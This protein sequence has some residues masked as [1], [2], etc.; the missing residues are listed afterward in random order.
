MHG[1]GR[2]GAPENT[3]AL[4]K[5]I[6]DFF[7]GKGRIGEGRETKGRARPGRQKSAPRRGGPGRDPHFS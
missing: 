5:N 4:W 7:G 6:P 2:G 1:G 3:F